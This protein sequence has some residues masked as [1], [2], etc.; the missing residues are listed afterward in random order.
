[1]R[2]RRDI[3]GRGCDEEARRSLME[4]EVYAG[5]MKLEAAIQKSFFEYPLECT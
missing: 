5:C 1:M 3:S 4:S 2:E